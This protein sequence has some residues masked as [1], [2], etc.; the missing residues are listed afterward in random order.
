MGKNI[1]SCFSA[2]V[3]V[4]FTDKRIT[5]IIVILWIG[6]SIGFYD[7]LGAF[8]EL[9]F[10]TLG[11]SNHTKFM[12]ATLDT[13]PKW[14]YVAS[15]SLLNTCVNEFVNDALVPWVQNTIQDHKTRALPYGKL[16]CVSINIMF[17]IYT[18]VTMLFSMFLYMSQI[19]F[20][21]L[22]IA[23]DIFVTLYSTHMFLKAKK[24]DPEAYAKE[25]SNNNANQD[26]CIVPLICSPFAMLNTESNPIL[27]EY[28]RIPM[29]LNTAENNNNGYRTSLAQGYTTLTATVQ[30][31]VVQ[32]SVVQPSSTLQPQQQ[33][34]GTVVTGI[35]L[36]ILRGDHASD[37]HYKE[38][39]MQSKNK[40]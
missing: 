33:A 7:E 10:L 30:P 19:D 6:I 22:R 27:S 21:L 2:C 18:Q 32:P 4:A 38:E 40:K 17:T 3:G 14:G 37:Y 26:R 39:T 25:S 36:N 35:P 24:V 13:W 28:P 15:F 12:G 23:G 29:S 1:F 31:S 16:T 20:L 9:D 5:C 8:D 34:E 11:P